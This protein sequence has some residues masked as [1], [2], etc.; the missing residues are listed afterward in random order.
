M[1]QR[2]GLNQLFSG[3]PPGRHRHWLPPAWES[4]AFP[5]IF[6]DGTLLSLTLTQGAGEG[7]GKGVNS[8]AADLFLAPH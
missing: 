8:T 7:V 6:S 5:L 3:L 4:Q 1:L 2:K